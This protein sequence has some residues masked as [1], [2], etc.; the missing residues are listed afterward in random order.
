MTSDFRKLSAEGKGGFSVMKKKIALLMSLVLFLSAV[1]FSAPA[2]VAH[3]ATRQELEAE[4]SRIDQEISS[5]KTKLAELKDK[6][7]SQQEYL[8][9]LENQISAN[10]KKATNLK[11]QVE[12]LDSEIDS[13]DKELKQLNTEIDVIK[14]EIVLANQ[15][16]TTTTNS[17]KASKTQLSQKIRAAYVTGTDSNLKL[18]MGADSLASFLTRLEMMKRMSENDKKVIDKFKSEVTTLKKTKL[19]L[20]K[21][22][23][24]LDEKQKEVVENKN[25]RIS[26]KAE[27]KTTQAEYEKAVKELESDY[28]EVEAYIAELD[29]SSAVYETYIKNLESERAAA[30]KEIESLIKNYQATTVAT[31]QGTTLYA[32]NNDPAATTTGTTSSSGGNSGSSSGSSGKIYHSN[33]SWA[34]P[35]GNI[36]CYISSPYGN[37]SAS[38]SGWS[39]HGGMDISASG[40]YG[41]PIYASRAGTVIAAVWGTTGYGRYVIIDHGDGFSTV[42]GHCSELVVQTGQTVA[43]GQHIANVGSTGNSTGPH[44]HFE[45]RYNGEKQNPA[46]YVSMP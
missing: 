5:N 27:L 26:R 19:T 30:D 10:E 24:K 42:Y 29:K 40:V 46:N 32:A 25:E 22:Q 18:I 33:D 8:D 38:I 9:T 7:E 45:V 31:T 44:L 43:K 13:L 21:K 39:F 11:T 4:L 28:A 16:I 2:P 1:M 17:I 15:Q 36:S 41:K 37:R 34:W 20:E 23:N 35:L 3:A 6:K 14:D 12:T